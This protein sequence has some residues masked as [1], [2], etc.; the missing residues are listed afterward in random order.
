MNGACARCLSRS[1]LLARLAGHLDHE[2]DRLPEL[3]ALTPAKLIA[4][5][6][7]SHRKELSAEFRA[8]SVESARTGAERAGLEQI[9]SCR[10]AYP[11]LL[12]QLP[13]PPTV[14]H[15]TGEVDRALELL[16][17]PVVAVV[18]ARE[19]SPYGLEAARSLGYGLAAAGVTVVSG[20]ARG[21][22][23]AA[24]RGALDAEGPT[25]AVLPA[26]PER[27]YPP[28]ARA[29]HQ[30][31]KSTGAVISELPAGT[32][33]RNWMFPAR[34]RIIAALAMMTVVVEARPGSGALITAYWA[35]ELYRQLGAV[36]GRITSPLARGPHDL[37]RRRNAQ[38]VEG[39]EDVLDF[40]CDIGYP[41]RSQIRIGPGIDEE[42]QRLLDALAEGQPA[43][44][45]LE[46][47]GY[48]TE[49]GLAALAALELQGAIARGPGGVYTVSSRYGPPTPS[50]VRA[51]DR[52]L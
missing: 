8:F 46:R 20:L 40:L 49:H 41:P 14:L 6:G 15:I 25:V 2:R 24:H 44:A 27:P 12:E 3:L 34:N 29:L 48:D 23:S 39:P 36:P 1:W 50:S 43:E 21:I 7:G 52:G 4:R 19:A 18:G 9:C 38:L 42:L 45:A 10:A 16:R 28:R 33:V 30:R 22:D 11:S 51:L 17:G 31:I 47:A 35:H 37:L 13:A 26:A 32:P 5:V